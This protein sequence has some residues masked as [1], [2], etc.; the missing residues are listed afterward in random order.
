MA[1]SVEATA[2]ASGTP[3]SGGNVTITGFTVT[4]ANRIMVGIG[5]GTGSADP[6]AVIQS[7]DVDRGAQTFTRVSSSRAT[8]GVFEGV[9]WWELTSPTAGSANIV[10]TNAIGGNIQLFVCAISFIDSTGISA[11]SINTGTSANPTVTVAASASGNIVVSVSANDNSTGGTTQSGTLIGEAEDVSSDSD[12]NAQYQTAIGANTVCVWVNIGTG[13][14]WAA[15]GLA[16]TGAASGLT[17]GIAGETDSAQPITRA[18]RK[19]IGISAETD[20]AIAVT[21]T[22]A[23]IANVANETDSAL[24]VGRSKAKAAGIASETDTAFAVSGGF[25][26]SIGIAT[27]TDSALSI[28]REK[29]KVIGVASETDSA[30]S[31]TTSTTP[32]ATFN[33]RQNRPR[34]GRG[35]FSIGKFYV[36]NSANS[37]LVPNAGFFVTTTF[38]AESDAAMPVTRL[39]AKPLGVASEADLARTLVLGGAVAVGI[40]QETDSARVITPL[41]ARAAGIAAETD[42]AIAVSRLH[43]KVVGVSQELD[44]AVIMSHTGGSAVIPGKSGFAMGM[45]RTGMR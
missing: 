7:G 10:V 14:G 44:Q 35:P 19:T 4:S 30:I 6:A 21:H 15:S 38:A 22:K 40:S 3:T 8:D 39:K 28:S 43:S 5:V 41:K 12:F 27:E 25:L 17:V 29:A 13:D 36:R 32:Q 26:T 20:S 16:V 37:G 18:K 11:A 24:A 42:S 34:P 45:R 33:L 2:S 31:I 1:F 23:R 9:E